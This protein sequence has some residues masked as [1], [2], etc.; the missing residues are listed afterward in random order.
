MLPRDK[1]LHIDL[2]CIALAC[3]LLALFLY[4]RFTIGPT[5]AF[6]SAVAGLVYL[7]VR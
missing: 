3:A 5:L 4:A 2:G 1:L 7:A 6:W